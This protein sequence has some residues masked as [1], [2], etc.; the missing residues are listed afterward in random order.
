VTQ[1][2]DWAAADIPEG[3]WD[4]LEGLGYVTIDPE[5]NRLYTP[6]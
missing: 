3:L 5:A 4:D 2:L 1:A 6:G